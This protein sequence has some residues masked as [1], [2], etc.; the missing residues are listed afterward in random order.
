MKQLRSNVV[1]MSEMECK[2]H[3]NFMGMGEK[4]TR[5]ERGLCGEMRKI[6][7]YGGGW[8]RETRGRDLEIYWGEYSDL[9]YYY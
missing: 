7:C 4:M 6:R 8:Y 2:M 1:G 3:G 9:L 5:E